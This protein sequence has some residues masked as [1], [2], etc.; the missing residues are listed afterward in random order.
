[1]IVTAGL[2]AR[3]WRRTSRAGE[4]ETLPS[5]KSSHSSPRT[6]LDNTT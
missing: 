4:A 6:V 2:A 1:M 3:R 5:V